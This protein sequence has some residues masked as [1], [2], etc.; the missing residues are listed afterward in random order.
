MSGEPLFLMEGFIVDK[1]II[2]DGLPICETGDTNLKN[3]LLQIGSSISESE[4]AQEEPTTYERLLEKTYKLQD[5]TPYIF[6]SSE[7]GSEVICLDE[8]RAIDYFRYQHF[9]DTGGFPKKKDAKED[10]DLLRLHALYSRPVRPV[11]YR[12][13]KYGTQGIELK[14]DKTMSAKVTGSSIELGPHEGC[15]WSP[16]NEMDLPQ[17]D[18]N[19]SIDPFF[20]VLGIESSDDR[21]LLIGILLTYLYPSGPYPITVLKGPQ[22]SSKSTTS[23]A[24]KNLV[25]SSLIE[26]MAEVKS[27]RDLYVVARVNRVLNFDN[28]SEISD[29]QYDAHC[30]IATGGQR[31]ERKLYTNKEMTCVKTENPQIINGIPNLFHREDFRE[32]SILIELPMIRN[33]RSLSDVKRDLE[34]TRAGAL[35]YLLNAMKHALANLETTETPQGIRMA[36]AAKLVAAAEGYLGWE[37]KTFENLYKANQLKSTKESL[38]EYPIY[39]VMKRLLDREN[40]RVTGTP[41]KVLERLNAMADSISSLTRSDEKWPKSPSALSRQLNR[42][43]GSLA[44]INIHV[45]QEHLEAGSR[46]TTLTYVQDN[47]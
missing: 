43:E 16:D 15:F 32:R 25:D 18:L 47:T 31:A 34:A 6:D 40:G 14:I 42:L 33:R 3:C 19:G 27:A 1:P 11:F 41:T 8:K 30:T 37:P 21:K 17:P 12:T 10:V 13:Q 26:K 4:D 24:I 9:M 44:C 23:A 5:G 29:K 2:T 35:G 20:D 28:V 39:L 46:R 22:G 7:S 36:D 38:S 45:H